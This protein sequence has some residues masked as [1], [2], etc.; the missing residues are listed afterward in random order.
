MKHYPEI[1][2]AIAKEDAELAD[3]IWNGVEEFSHRGTYLY[4][5][6]VV[7]VVSLKIKWKTVLP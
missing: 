2:L 6:I 7:V 5:F 4:R 3:C 1:A